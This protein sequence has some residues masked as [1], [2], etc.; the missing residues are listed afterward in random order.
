MIKY[1]IIILLYKINIGLGGGNMKKFPLIAPLIFIIILITSCQHKTT[2]TK[3]Q[4]DFSDLFTKSSQKLTNA[5]SYTIKQDVNL[6]YRN[7]HTNDY[8][9]TSFSLLMDIQKNPMIIRT[10]YEENNEQVI[11]Y[12]TEE[13][14]VIYSYLKEDNTYIKI[15]G[16]KLVTLEVEP[17]DIFFEVDETKLTK[18]SIYGDDDN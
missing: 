1:Y 16:E 15:L 5:K 14:G 17:S 7:Y 3:K 18:S 2:Q 12:I 8:Q 13:N 11:S 4:I 10:L 9:L 6:Q